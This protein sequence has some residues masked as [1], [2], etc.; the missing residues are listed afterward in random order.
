MEGKYK[1]LLIGLLLDGIGMLSLALPGLG[2]FLDLIWAPVAGWFMT[3]LY[4]GRQGKIAG[5]VAFLEE[6]LPGLDV[7]PSFTLMWIYTFLLRRKQAERN[8]QK[9]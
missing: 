9:A 2:E 3:R 6:L 4:P 8:P 1:K 5:V 7:I